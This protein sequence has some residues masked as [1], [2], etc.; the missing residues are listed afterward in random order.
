MPFM[1]LM[2]RYPGN[3]LKGMGARY[4][5]GVFFNVFAR[6]LDRLPH[7]DASRSAAPRRCSA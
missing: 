4:I 3:M 1:D 6:V 2:R 5:D 7:H